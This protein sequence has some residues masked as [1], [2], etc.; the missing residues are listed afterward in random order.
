MYATFDFDKRLYS[1]FFLCCSISVSHFIASNET[2]FSLLAIRLALEYGKIVP[3]NLLH[4]VIV[5]IFYFEAG[6]EIISFPL[7]FDSYDETSI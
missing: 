7:C 1:I 5:E 4:Y 2:D 3:R 6:F